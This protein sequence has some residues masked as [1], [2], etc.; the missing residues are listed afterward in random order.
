MIQEIRIKN[1]RSFKDE[2]V[3]N[4]EATKDTFAEESQVVTISDNVRLLR[5]AIV[6]GY[7][8]SGKSNLL[9]AIDFLFDFWFAK[10]RDTDEKIKQIEP[11]KLDACSHYE[12]TRFEITFYI[13]ST[14]YNYLLELDK[15]QVYI[16][17]LSYYKSV[18]PTML[19]ER[20]LH[21]G[22]TDINYGVAVQIKKIVKDNILIK[23]LTN[24]SFFAARTQINAELP[25]IDAVKDY[26]KSK[27][28]RPI[29]PSTD[30]TKYAKQ[31]LSES[32]EAVSYLLKFL[33]E[34]DFNITNIKTETIK[35]NPSKVFF[36]AISSINTLSSD[37]KKKILKIVY[38]VKRKASFSHLVESN[39]G[40]ETYSLSLEKGE[41]SL[42]TERVMG[43]EAALYRGLKRQS[44]LAI[45]EIESS[46]HPKLLEKV[47][48]E[49]LK[50]ENSQSQLIVTTHNDGLLDL[51]DDL[52]RK[53][54]VWFTEKQKNGATDLYRL[55][56]FKGLN[57]LSS[58]REAYR[59]KRFGAT[60]NK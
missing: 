19:F 5:F 57:R 54:S 24:M 56:D 27:I 59:L 36:D 2:V 49:F 22:Q 20:Q 37:D 40:K 60:M 32:K 14:K 15:Q 45:D 21:D 17:K 46:L 30:L 35:N 43:V 8:A 23:C 38:E 1:F 52:I 18:Q 26:F 7:N 29:I 10:T 47:L 9:R 39:N 53:D 6:Y 42:G 16:E 41:E 48:Y 34:A 51:T 4:F 55:T 13:D 28:F 44:L 50:I 3:F 25:I 12:H 58:I 33:R 31:L 11:F